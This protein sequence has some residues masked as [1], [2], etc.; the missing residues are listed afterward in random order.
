MFPLVTELQSLT[1]LRCA[2]GLWQ[3]TPGDW[4]YTMVLDGLNT[5]FEVRINDIESLDIPK[6]GTT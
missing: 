1:V 5:V 4:H 3:A 6:Y 2:I